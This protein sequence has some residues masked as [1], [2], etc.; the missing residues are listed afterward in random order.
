MKTYHEDSQAR[1]PCP[2]Q[3]HSQQLIP[4]ILL[5]PDAWH[6]AHASSTDNNL[7]C[8]EVVAALSMKELLHRFRATRHGRREVFNDITS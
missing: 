4:A 2:S 3:V 6:P 5:N 7:H 1:R 8:H